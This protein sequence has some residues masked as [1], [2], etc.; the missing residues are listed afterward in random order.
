MGTSGR[1][2]HLCID[3]KGYPYVSPSVCGKQRAEKAHIMICEAFHGPRP[4]GYLVR[5]KDGCRVNCRPDN[6]AYGT[7]LENQR[8]RI[9][10]GTSN[11]GERSVNARVTEAEVR[12]IRALHALKLSLVEIG[13]RYGIAASTV[14]LIATGRRWAHVDDRDFRITIASHA[15]VEAV[16]LRRMTADLQLALVD[17]GRISTAERRTTAKRIR[18]LRDR[19]ADLE[20]VALS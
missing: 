19:A 8:D 2:L 12:E 14:S 11:R 15:A 13:D 5:H 1:V 16:R 18:R 10:H 17:D 7:A 4:A 3:K 20:K 9:E 6:L